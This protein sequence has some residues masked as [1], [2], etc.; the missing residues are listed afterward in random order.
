MI[1]FRPATIDDIFLLK[2]WDK[3]PHVIAA[4]PNDEWDWKIELQ[5]TPEWREQLIAE[6]DGRPVGIVQIIDPALEE[7]RYWGNISKGYRAIDIWIGY[8]ADLGK[9]YGAQMMELAFDRCFSGT[10]VK[11]IL[12]DPLA[13]NTQAHRFYERLGF[14]FMERRWFGKDYCFVYRLDRDKW[15]ILKSNI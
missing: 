10:D 6:T 7:S 3:Q 8:K 11:A 1:N 2:Q 14:E 9:G 13:S 5:Y 12:I 15:G 4:N